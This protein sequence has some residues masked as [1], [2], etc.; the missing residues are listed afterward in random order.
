LLCLALYALAG[1]ATRPAAPPAGFAAGSGHPAAGPSGRAQGATCPQPC[2]AALQAGHERGRAVYQ[3]RALL[4]RTH[5]E[6]YKLQRDRADLEQDKHDRQAAL[7]R[8]DLPPGARVELLYEVHR[9]DTQLGI[10]GERLETLEQQLGFRQAQL[11]RL[12]K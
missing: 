1:C 2:T 6:I 8:N 4:N 11:D 10:L 3:A 7:V 9:I 5:S 12:E